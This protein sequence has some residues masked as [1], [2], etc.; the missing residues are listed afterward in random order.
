MT[1]EHECE[2]ANLGCGQYPCVEVCICNELRSAYQRGREDA[3]KAVYQAWQ[4][5]DDYQ[6]IEC[7]QCYTKEAFDLAEDAARGDDEQV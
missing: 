1:H 5:F 2:K 6:E 3:A 7:Q 4:K